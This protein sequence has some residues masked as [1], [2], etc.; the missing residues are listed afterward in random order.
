MCIDI[1]CSILKTSNKNPYNIFNGTL[2]KINACFVVLVT[3]LYYSSIVDSGSNRN[4]N[5]MLLLFL[6]SVVYMFNTRTWSPSKFGLFHHT[7]LIV[8]ILPWVSFWLNLYFT[9]A[10]ISLGLLTVLTM[11]T[12]SQG[13]KASLTRVAYVKAVDIW[14]S[15]CLFFVCS[16]NVLAWV[17]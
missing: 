1:L 14:I 2:F 16:V 17:D 12:Q 5:C 10:R 15:T 9:P 11:T 7:S 8:V 3:Y 13:A 6:S 4:Q